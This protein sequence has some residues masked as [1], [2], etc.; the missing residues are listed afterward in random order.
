[1]KITTEIITALNPC[2]NRFKN[3]LEHHKDFD[4]THEDF[5]RLV[6]ISPSDKL[7]VLLR[8][9]PKFEVEVFA[10]D[11]AVASADYVSYAADAVEKQRQMEALI[12]LINNMKEES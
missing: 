7:W 10:I 1:M 6:M 2:K 9:I 5:A 12:C 8:L 3:Y 4:G 11:C